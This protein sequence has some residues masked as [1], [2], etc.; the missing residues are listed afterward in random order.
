MSSE[1]ESKNNKL[2]IDFGSLSQSLSILVFAIEL[3]TLFF[4]LGAL[5]PISVTIGHLS[6]IS[7]L[8][9]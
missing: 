3:V 8:L 7:K 9:K 6:S 1:R 2:K 4:A 5:A